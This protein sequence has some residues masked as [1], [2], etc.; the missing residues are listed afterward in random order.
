MTENKNQMR[1]WHVVCQDC[2]VENDDDIVSS[3][4]KPETCP[5]CQ[6]KRVEVIEQAG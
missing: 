3:I 5:K 1:Y 2:K 6:S 4:K